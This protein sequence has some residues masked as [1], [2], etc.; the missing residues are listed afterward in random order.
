MFVNGW[1][2]GCREP[3]DAFLANRS[4]WAETLFEPV[5]SIRLGVEGINLT[6]PEL[7]YNAMPL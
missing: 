6:Y 5:M 4:S 7:A 3:A 1:N 2:Y